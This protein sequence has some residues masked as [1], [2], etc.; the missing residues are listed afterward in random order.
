M[1]HLLLYELTKRL[2]LLLLGDQFSMMSKWSF[3]TFWFRDSRSDRKL[4]NILFLGFVHWLKEFYV[5]RELTKNKNSN[6]INFYY[7]IK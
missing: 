7:K 6:I 4:V 5:E 1:I 3:E 2:L